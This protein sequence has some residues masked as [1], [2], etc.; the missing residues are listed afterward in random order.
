MPL[1]R[2]FREAH[3]LLST[4]YKPPDTG[5]GYKLDRMRALLK[6]LGDP[7]DSL[8]IVHVAGTSGKTSTCYYLAALLQ[9][10]GYT[11]GLT[12]SPHIDE[13]N[14]R[15]QI[16]LVSLA[17]P[18]FC[19]ALSSFVDLVTA[20]H[21]QPSYFELLVAMALYEFKRRAL[22]YAVVEVGI[23]GLLDTTNV[24]SRPDK[25]C[26][27]TDI[28]LD[29]TTIL[30]STVEQIAAQKAGI[31][32]P[33]NQ[34]FVYRQASAIMRPIRQAAAKADATLHE[35][36]PTTMVAP[37][38][39]PLFQ[40]RNFYLAKQAAAYMLE[41]DRLPALTPPQLQTAAAVAIPGRMEVYHLGTKTIILDG[42]HN[43]QKMA[44]LIESIRDAFPNQPLAALLVVKAGT[45]RWQALLDLLTKAVSSLLLT[46]F[47]FDDKAHQKSTACVQAV[48][49]YLT[50]HGVSAFSL[51]P[52]LATACRQLL[53]QPEPVLLVTGS[54]FAIHAARQALRL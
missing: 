44:A 16:D 2:N 46:P 41:R 24:M 22:D 33:H 25:V 35:V 11:V 43:E 14:E 40:Q 3:Q 15:L 10:A 1:V 19:A 53:R 4:F 8:R 6:A 23:G 47:G 12:V 5:R 34:V 37:S 29:H 26:V 13:V 17:E 9:Q 52:D 48:A 51:A 32:Q 39:L 30:G 31:I 42:A 20:T 54:L 28:G 21:I 27:I 45:G 18:A 7:Q 50:E 38:S 49:S 36:D